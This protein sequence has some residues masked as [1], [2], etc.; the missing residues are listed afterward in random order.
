MTGNSKDWKLACKNIFLVIFQWHTTSGFW[1]MFLQHSL[2][3]LIHLILY[4]EKI[5]GDKQLKQW[6]CADLILRI[7]SYWCF[8]F[9]FFT[10]Y[11][12]YFYTVISTC[13]KDYDFG[14]TELFANR[15]VHQQVN[16]L[17]DIILNV[18]TNFVPNKVITCDDRD[19]PGSMIMIR[20]I[21]QGCIWSFSTNCE[22]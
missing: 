13:F 11:H 6:L 20:V 4:G 12:H 8:C 7:V 19:H 17:N 22:E 21:D 1:T 16:L 9:Y 15:T 5:I 3:R 14:I 2:T 18:F 10:W